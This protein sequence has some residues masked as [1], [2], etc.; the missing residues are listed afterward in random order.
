MTVVSPV[1]TCPSCTLAWC[2]TDSS[3]LYRL[4]TK[5]DGWIITRFTGAFLVLEI[6]QL[7]PSPQ[8]LSEY[9]THTEAHGKLQHNRDGLWRKSFTVAHLLH[10]QQVLLHLIVP[11]HRSTCFNYRR[12][13][14]HQS[15]YVFFKNVQVLTQFE[16]YKR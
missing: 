6:H 4:S 1:I 16:T 10:Q 11:V 5:E 15:V 3:P 9:L 13:R 7:I 8:L 14:S 12:K 2:V